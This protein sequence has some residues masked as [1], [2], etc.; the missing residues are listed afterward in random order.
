MKCKI[1][2]SEYKSIIVVSDTTTG[3]AGTY[4]SIAGFTTFDTTDV[5][6]VNFLNKSNAPPPYINA[7]A[8]IL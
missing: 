3:P 7:E 4:R 8:G 2:G 5:V 6:V 1:N